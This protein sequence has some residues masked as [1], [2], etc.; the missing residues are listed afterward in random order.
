MNIELGYNIL[1][2][3]KTMQ[4]AA[5][6][7][8]EQFVS[9][10]MELFDGLGMD[11]G[12]GLYAVRELAKAEIPVGSRI[13]LEDACTC[14][15]ESLKD[16]KRLV[17]T[18]PE[19]VEWKLEYELGAIIETMAIQFFYWGIVEA[20]PEKRKEF[21]D[22]LADAEMFELLKVS[23]QER[24][25]P[26][27]LTIMVTAYDHLDY[28]VQ[29]VESI[30]ENW[31]REA[32]CELILFNHGSTDGTKEYFE[33]IPKIKVINT[34]VNNAIPY[35]MLRAISG[36]RYSL[37]VSNDI[38]IGKN[39]IDN[40]YRC[41][42]EHPEY[43]Y[44]V[45]ATSAVS[46]LQSL[47]VKYEGREQF[48]EVTLK[49]N[50]YDEKRHEQRV[51]LCNPLHIMPTEL[52]MQMS[53]DMYEEKC[54]SRLKL[55]FPDDRNSL[56]MR[57]NGY[58]CILA[59]D[60]YCHHFGSVTIGHEGT[61]AE[62]DQFYEDGR[63]VFQ[64]QHGIDPW[65]TGFGYD[66][67]LIDKWDLPIID[68]AFILGIN[69]GLGGNSLKIKEVLR[70]KGAENIRLYN[71]VQDRRYLKDL[72]GISDGAFLF[73]CLDEVVERTKNDYYNYIIIEE[74]IAGCVGRSMKRE[75]L[76]AGLRFDQMACKMKDGTWQIFKTL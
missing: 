58:K 53:L 19:K 25:Y 12:D 54:C 14:A 17:Y 52:A 60:A 13:R 6:E 28:S 65:G 67:E 11:L 73:E 42:K 43:G 38:V 68:N 55:S 74:P 3:L 33:N 35:V 69:C 45:P 31:P 51:R 46:N 62:R 76:D 18:K 36:G 24:K 63:K 8:K 20:H 7:M 16:I 4:D 37:Q 57:R 71:I 2:I 32:R 70:E 10:G 21:L 44:I 30:L 5:K 59:K 26:Y 64:E 49:N 15:L 72:E 22:F 27:D 23:E 29:C 9:G 50:V 40:L 1:D 34:A 75:L 47:P 56:W 61:S 41:A 66:L 39:A 48:K